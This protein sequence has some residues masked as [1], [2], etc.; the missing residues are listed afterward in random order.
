MIER[1]S[2]PKMRQLWTDDYKYSQWLAVE[3][4]VVQ[5]WGKLGVVPQ[6]DVAAVESKAGYDAAEISRL[7]AITHHDMVAFTRCVS[8]KLGPEKK[9]IHY[10]LTSTDVIDTAYAVIFKQADGIIK[11]DLANLAAVLKKKAVE[12]KD[13]PCIGRTHGMHADITSFGLKYAIWYDELQ[14]DIERFDLA[15]RQMEVGKITGAVGN[16]ANVPPFVQEFVCEKLAIGSAKTAT[17]VI[18]RDNHAFYLQTIALIGTTLEK[19]ATEFRHLQRSEVGEAEEYFNPGQKGSSAMPHKRNPISLEN[20]CGCARVLRGYQLTGLEDV[21][22][23]HERDI[24]HSSAERII[25]P[26]ATALLDYMLARFTKTLDSMIIY[27]EKM[28][29]NINLTDGVIY[30]QR[31]M[32][33]LIDAGASREQAY[34][35]IQKLAMISL[36]QHKDFRILASQDPYISLHL[37]PDQLQSCYTMDFYFRHIDEIYQRCGLL[38]SANN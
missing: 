17:Q 25:M 28:L 2:R 22:L 23:W 31:V 4:A 19:I 32:T 14:R 1:Y 15:S 16:Y 13:V 21:S 18:S 7:E 34:D 5:A 35:N 11:E 10:G 8:E 33:A 6:P 24:S 20:I 36:N 27:P 3:I 38:E 37:N 9:W 12:Y 26:D 30:A 29:A